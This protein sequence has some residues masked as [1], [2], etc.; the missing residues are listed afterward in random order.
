MHISILLTSFDKPGSDRPRYQKAA[1]SWVKG[2][3]TS[4]QEVID[5]PGVCPLY[6]LEMC[7]KITNQ[8]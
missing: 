1:E 2:K 3:R 4:K 6:R 5:V 7:F 8:S